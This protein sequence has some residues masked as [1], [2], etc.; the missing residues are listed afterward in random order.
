M[1]VSDSVAQFARI[2]DELSVQDNH[3]FT[4]GGPGQLFDNEF[5]VILNEFTKRHPRTKLK[6]H[7]SDRPEEANDGSADVVIMFNLRIADP[8]IVCRRAGAMQNGFYAAHEY[9]AINDPPTS[10][11]DLGDHKFIGLSGKD[12]PGNIMDWINAYVPQGQIISEVT[13]FQT[14]LTEIRMGHGIGPLP[15][16]F[17]D[18]Q[19][20]L[21]RALA[22]T[23]SLDSPC[24]LAIGP[25]ASHRPILRKFTRF[26]APRFKRL[27]DS[28]I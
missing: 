24:W 1:E 25:H 16:M 3:H 4:L 18:L 22:P 12:L 20:G 15:A 21:V 9:A 26:F 14:L 27:L 19:D 28:R 7:A 8:N 17:G 11:T 5:T 2:A 13:N 10:E 23:T 6:V